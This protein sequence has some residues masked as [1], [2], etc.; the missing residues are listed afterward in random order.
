LPDNLP[1][2]FFPFGVLMMMGSHF[3]Q[4][5]PP[6]GFCSLLS[7]SH[8]RKVLLRPPSAGLVSCRSRPWG[9]PSGPISTRRAVRSF[10][11]RY[12]LVVESRRTPTSGSCSLRVSLSP[13]AEADGDSDPPGI[14]LPR[15][16]PFSP[17]SEDHPLL[18]FMGDEP[19]LIDHCSAES[20]RRKSWLDSLES[21]SP[22]E[23][24]SPCQ[25][26]R[27]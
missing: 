8:A 12:P 23:V 7:V 6:P 5:Y 15:V 10:E 25:Q 4:G 22:F 13:P 20:Y 11:R 1:C 16:S 19:K 18:S 17:W 21:A 26:P 2:G 14:D 24:L 3:P 9:F 27:D